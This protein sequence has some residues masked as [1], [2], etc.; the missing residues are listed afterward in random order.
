MIKALL[1]IFEPVSGWNGVV[2]RNRGTAFIFVL[3]VL[4]MLAL[5]TAA[6]LAGLLHFGHTSDYSGT[7]VPVARNLL[8]YYG[9][10]EF[11]LSLATLLLATYVL[12]SFGETF[13]SRHT[14]NQCF[15]VVA[16]SLSPVFLVR[17]LDAFP[18]MN[19]WASLGIGIVLAW[20][21]LYQGIPRVLEP[22]PPHAFG[23]YLSS[24]LALGVLVGLSRFLSL[25]ILWG[26][27]KYLR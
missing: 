4:P 24:A 16:H 10:G 17:L 6:Q 7:V 1:L 25:L 20:S 27:I 26:K 14:F 18:W 15:S 5:C 11:V 3:Y 8:R 2:E 21:V 22:D 23:L 19:P 12:K 9:A 13:H